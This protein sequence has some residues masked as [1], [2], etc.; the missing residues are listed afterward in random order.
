MAGLRLNGMNKFLTILTS[1]L[2]D[3]QVQVSNGLNHLWKFAYALLCSQKTVG[4]LWE[5]S[6]E[7]SLLDE[8]DLLDDVGVLQAF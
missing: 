5:L 6:R 8:S 2:Q 7:L 4:I 3:G 1:K